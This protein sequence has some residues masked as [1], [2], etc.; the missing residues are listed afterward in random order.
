M[1]STPMVIF[2]DGHG[3]F[4]PM[5]DLRASFEI[6][7]GMLTTAGRLAASRPEPLGGYW[8]PP[9]LAPVVAERADA[10]VNRLPAA[11]DMLCVNGRW[12][13]PQRN[14]SLKRGQAALEEGSGHVVAVRLDHD[15]AQRFLE[16]GDLP[17][18]V[19]SRQIGRDLL[20]VYP[21]DVLSM[22]SEAIR[23]DM[24]AVRILDAKVPTDE[25]TVIGGH[26]VEVHRSAKLYPNVVLDAERGPVAIHERAVIRP[27]A[28]LSGPCSIGRDCVVIDHASIKPNTVLGPVCKVGGEVGETVFQGFSNKSHDGHLGGSWVGKW[29]NFGAGTVNSNLLNTY[30][31]VWMAVEPDDPAVRTGLTYLGCVVG[32]HVK[33]AIGTRIATGGVVGTGAMI[34]TTA[35]PPKT[36]RRF[37]WLT[38][39]GESIYRFDEFMRMAVR[40]MTRR[41][42][43]PSNAYEQVLREL[44]ARAG[45]P[46]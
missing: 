8:A 11:K 28:V 35:P 25:A 18:G 10:P 40:V 5:T 17:D 37:A 14:L 15:D 9:N 33:F 29:V 38:D 34:A 16:S 46:V 30:G 20:Y 22:L 12:R 1:A 32:D 19:E 3:R 6:R 43:V 21:W 45:S 42:Q 26:P 24:S 31:D 41:D 2:D 4:G 13:L 7:T 27:G 39:K 44:H 36:V 23:L